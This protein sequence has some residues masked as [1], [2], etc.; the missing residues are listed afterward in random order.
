MS[1]FGGSFDA[2]VD[3]LPRA[4]L[5][6]RGRDGTHARNMTHSMHVELALHRAEL[7]AHSTCP[8]PLL[9]TIDITVRQH[10]VEVGEVI[11]PVAPCQVFAGG[12]TPRRPK[13]VTTL[14][15]AHVSGEVVPAKCVFVSCPLLGPKR[16]LRRSGCNLRGFECTVFVAFTAF[17]LP[18]GGKY[19]LSMWYLGW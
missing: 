9:R 6:R 5:E 15:V 11:I 12:G 2:H 10:L 8:R 13:L 14:A 17:E 1:S 4:L 7:A 18:L 19:D 3:E 16:L